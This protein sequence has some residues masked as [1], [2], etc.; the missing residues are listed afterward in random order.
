MLARRSHV[1]EK[2]IF[3]HWAKH[4]TVMIAKLARLLREKRARRDPTARDERGGSR[5]ARGK[6]VNF[7]ISNNAIK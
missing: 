3:L 4:F 7:A 6:R 5:I 2:A 1:M